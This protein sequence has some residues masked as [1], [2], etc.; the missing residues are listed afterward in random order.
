[1]DGSGSR[2]LAHR[3][4]AAAQEV[5]AVHARLR[6]LSGV[7]WSS[8]AATGFRDQLDEV[9]M[10]LARTGSLLREAG[11]AWLHHASVIETTGL[12]PW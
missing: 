8:P 3:F 1:M 10:H 4:E 7:R 6:S 12:Q 5:D 2:Q 9:V 11:G